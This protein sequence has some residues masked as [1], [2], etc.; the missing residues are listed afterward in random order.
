MIMEFIKK[1]Q[2]IIIL[3][4]KIRSKVIITNINQLDPIILKQKQSN[5]IIIFSFKI[6]NKLNKV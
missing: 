1:I 2:I 5:Q 6:N 3:F 4:N